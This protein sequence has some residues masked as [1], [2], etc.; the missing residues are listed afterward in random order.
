MGIR[1]VDMGDG[2]FFSGGQQVKAWIFPGQGSQYVNM[3]ASFDR[4]AERDLIRRS[5]ELLN[6]DMEA[7]LSGKDNLLDQTQW[8]QPALL[9]LSTLYSGRVSETLKVFPDLVLGHSLG[10]YSAL[11]LAGALSFEETLIAVHKRGSFMQE[12]V[13]QGEGLMAAVLGMER[14]ALV[15]ILEEIRKASSPSAG[16]IGAANFNSPGQIVIAGTRSLVEDSFE[17]LRKAGARKIVPL[18]VSV[19]SHTPLM[20]GAAKKMEEVLDRMTW[21]APRCPVI[22]NQTATASSDPSELKIR[23]VEQIRKPVLWEDCI[24]EAIR[25]GAT[26]FLEVGPGSVLTGLG[27]KIAKEAE[28]LSSD[29]PGSL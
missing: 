29:R 13:P 26:S 18:S 16:F 22:S 11:V 20:D 19:P 10:E 6:V 8:T 23:L 7:I 25:L 5:G 2:S 4:P 12:A 27:K 28:W 24:R 1:V 15:D 21:K 17:T 14:S 9:L 3:A